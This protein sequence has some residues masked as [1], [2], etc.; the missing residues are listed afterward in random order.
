MLGGTQ[1]LEPIFA[2]MVSG[3]VDALVVN[4]RFRVR[5]SSRSRETSSCDGS[6]N[7]A[8]ADA[9]GLMSYAGSLADRYR[10]AAPYVDK[11]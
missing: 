1:D 8:F 7:R 5:R 3:G 4:Q 10:N 6:G 11:I 2:G 9:G